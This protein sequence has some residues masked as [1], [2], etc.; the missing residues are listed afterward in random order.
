MNKLDTLSE[1]E[2]IIFIEAVARIC[3]EVNRIFSMRHCPADPFPIPNW[4]G[5]PDWQKK[6]CINGVEWRLSNLDAPVKANHD[7]W[8]KHKAADGWAYGGIKDELLKEHPCMV[9][10]NRLPD[11]Q[12]TKDY[13]FTTIV[14]ASVGH[15]SD[16]VPF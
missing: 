15:A 6:S 10:F 7:N 1:S 9:H 14:R 12:Q 4:D 8:M 5:A 3:H 16:K 2:R 11:E 13:L